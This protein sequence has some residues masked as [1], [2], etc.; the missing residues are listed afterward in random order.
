MFEHK[1]E[2]EITIQ[3]RLCLLHIPKTGGV[4]LDSIIQQQFDRQKIAPF[5]YTPQLTQLPPGFFN[6]FS[7]Y[8]GHIYFD[9]VDN[10]LVGSTQFLTLLRTPLERFLSQFSYMQRSPNQFLK[11]HLGLTRQ[12]VDE[13]ETISLDEFV[14]TSEMVHKPNYQNY[15][16]Q[17]IGARFDFE[18]DNP[19]LP[20]KTAN[21]KP[22]ADLN[23]AKKRLSQFTF[24]GLTERFQDSLFLLAY[25]FGWPPHQ[26]A[27]WLNAAPTRLHGNQL[28]PQTLDKILEYNRL[29]IELYAY[30]QQLF[31]ERFNHMCHDLL[32]GYG[33]PAHTH[34]SLPLPTEVVFE[35]LQHHYRRR[36]KARY[37]ATSTISLT[38]DQAISGTGWHLPEVHNS[39]GIYRWT[40]PETCS[41]LDFPLTIDTVTHIK[42]S[43]I[44]AINP[45]LLNNLRLTV[46]GE[47]VALIHYPDGE[48]TIFEGCLSPINYPGEES[49]TQLEFQVD[50]TMKPCALD[51]SNDDDRLLGIA[52]NWLELKPVMDELTHRR[53]QT[54]SLSQKQAVLEQSLIDSNNHAKDLA[55]ALHTTK[56]EQALLAATLTTKTDEIATL[57]SQLDHQTQA[58][59]SLQS[60]YNDAQKTMHSLEA[61]I[62]A[63]KAERDSLTTVLDSKIQE[64]AELQTQL[65]EQ[66]QIH[67]TLQGVYDEAKDYAHSLE[68]ALHHKDAE[69]TALSSAFE[70]KA[71]KIVT[72]QAQLQEHIHSYQKLQDVYHDA[73]DYARSLEKSIQDRE[74]ELAQLRQQLHLIQES[75]AY[76]TSQQL[77]QLTKIF[78]SHSPKE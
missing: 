21:S 29:D 78:S 58:H 10:F 8:R 50:Q 52:L 42:F 19:Q 16:T 23:L 69:L 28:A 35:L 30:A 64:M 46:N 2:H 61:Q 27:P 3:D 22:H 60:L 17:L 40:G 47:Q 74:T 65:Q 1:I 33:Q 54:Q 37:T 72:L 34:L 48:T 7:Y 14:F 26:T 51:P 38:F 44:S 32:E 67:Y 39:R 9:F 45:D 6:T 13:F 59:E 63:S 41:T 71:Q 12:E 53:S 56:T 73:R 5:L 18:N 57:L 20:L 55:A 36:F 11:Y 4:T 76:K 62:K 25:T 66:M 24:L 70:N 15:E 75:R 31:E 49:Y 68:A 77:K 43:V